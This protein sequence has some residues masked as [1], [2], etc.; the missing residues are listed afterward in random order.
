MN[1]DTFL[2]WL[3]SLLIAHVGTFMVFALGPI[4]GCLIADGIVC[5]FRRRG[6]KPLVAAIVFFVTTIAIGLLIRDYG[7]SGVAGSPTHQQDMTALERNANLY[8]TFAVPLGL[9]AAAI[10]I[11]RSLGSQK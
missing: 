6:I 4:V 2:S 10:R 8:L 5:V 1:T 11:V 9:L 3:S 7:L